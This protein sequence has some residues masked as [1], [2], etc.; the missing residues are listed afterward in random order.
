MKNIIKSISL[1]LVLTL[2]VSCD[3]DSSEDLGYAAQEERGWV[4]FLTTNPAQIGVFQGA[5]GTIDLDVNI[6]VPTTSS[7]LTINYA[8]QSV[9]GADPNSVF[10][11]SGAIIAPAGKTSYAG[12]DNDTGFE[13]TYLAM[14]SLDLADLDGTT[15][16]ESMVFD[17][18]LTGTSSSSIT[19]GLE[20]E[21]K[22][23][24][25][26]VVINPSI[27]VFEGAY[28]V[29][30]IFT[31][32]TNAGLQ[33]ALAFGESYQVELAMIE[34]DSTASTMLVTNSDGF[35]SYYPTGTVM[36]FK[37]NGTLDV[38]D[39]AN[40]NIPYLAG[41][42]YHFVDSSS[43]DYASGVIVCSGDFGFPSNFG[44]YQTTLTRQ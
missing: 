5:T 39:G 26:R 22:P 29:N 17:V 43:Y 15:L 4:Q 16:T 28:S 35:D 24:S 1:L 6:Q 40:F 11:N 12:P 18:V 31:S 3:K 41:F 14:I 38:D 9:S 42:S 8:L 33:L 20:G 36:T 23:V 7:D 2:T 19:A 25:Q 13:Y 34:G 30:E 10:S 21:T 27:S 32:G 44:P 37:L